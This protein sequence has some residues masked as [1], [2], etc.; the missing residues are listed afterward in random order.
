ME[1]KIFA[2]CMVFLISIIVNAQTNCT[3]ELKDLSYGTHIVTENCKS[4]GTFSIGGIFNDNWEKLTFFYPN[5]W[6]GTYITVKVNDAVYSNSIPTDAI[7]LDQFFKKSS[8]SLDT[9]EL[10]FTWDLPEKILLEEKFQLIENGTIIKLKAKNYGNSDKEI[11]FRIHF[12]TMLGDND[13]A[14]IYI[15]GDGLI[16]N[17]KVYEQVYFPYWKAYNKKEKPNIV[18]QGIFSEEKNLTIPKKLIISNWRKS[19]YSLWDYNTDEKVS[20]LG[21]SAVILYFEEKNLKPLE[22]FNIET[23]YGIG[24]EILPE[25]NFGIVE[26]TTDKLRYCP[27]EDVNILVDILSREGEHSGKVL[28]S[29]KNSTGSEIFSEVKETGKIFENSMRTLQFNLKTPKVGYPLSAEIKLFENEKEV[30]R[31]E[32]VNVF[33]L[34]AD[35]GKVFESSYAFLILILLTAIFVLIAIYYISKKPKKLIF[36]KVRNKDT[37]RVILLNETDKVLENVL[38]TDTIPE[39][40]EVKILTFGVLRAK[41]LISWKIENLKAGEKAIIEYKIISQHR[42]P[43]Q[44]AKLK[45]D[46]EEIESEMQE[47]FL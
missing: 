7:P 12:D 44:K 24:E 32:K 21:D 3:I 27:D 14:P 6:H 36:K 47:E 37:I 46:S 20:I 30:D 35:C 2:F 28:L 16:T 26:I 1:N 17:E 4:I 42:E 25:K 41:N 34:R 11:A 19:I 33:S 45:F 8:L 43:L 22:E 10:T 40:S 39:N 23:F 31:K 18:S 15:P 13:G 29:I 38:I 9:K 5:P